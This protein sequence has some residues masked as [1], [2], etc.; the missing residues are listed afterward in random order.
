MEIIHVIRTDAKERDFTHPPERERER[1]DIP[2]RGR[3]EPIL[4]RSALIEKQQI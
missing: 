4:T 3:C 2:R 1:E